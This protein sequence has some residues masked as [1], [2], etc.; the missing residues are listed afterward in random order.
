MRKVVLSLAAAFAFS[1]SCATPAPPAAIEPVA[2]IPPRAAD[3]A[4]QEFQVMLAPGNDPKSG[5]LIVVANPAANWRPL[6]G[7]TLGRPRYLSPGQ[8][9]YVAAQ[10]APIVTPAQPTRFDAD[11]LAFP[12]PLSRIAPGEYWVQVRLDVDHDAAYGTA[13]DP[14]ADFVSVP[15]KMALPV[16]APVPITLQLERFVWDP[17][18]PGSAAAAAAARTTRSQTPP[19]ASDLL[20]TEADAHIKPID[21]L[22]SALS[23]FWGKPMHVRGLVLLPPDYDTSRDKYP[24]IYRTEGFGGSL[25]SLNGSARQHYR[26]MKSGDTP[27]MIRVF[28]DHSS[29]W[30]THEFADSVNN[31]PWGFALTE[32]L[33]PALEKQYRMDAKPSGRFTTGHSSG[34][35]FAIWQQ[36]RYPE[37]FGGTWARSPDPV[38]FRSFTGI[39]IYRDGAN[40]YVRP[41]GSAQYLVRDAAGKEI[42]SFKEYALQEN[43]LGDFGG[44]IDSFDWVFSPKGVDG[45]PQPLFDRATGKVD[46]EVARYWRDHFDISYLIR[47]DWKS[48]KPVLDGK[49]RLIMGTMDTFHLNE[50]AALLEQEM[51]KLGAKADFFWMEGRTHGN[52]DRVGDDPQGLEKKIAWEMYAVARPN[53]P[54]KPK[55]YVAPPMRSILTSRPQ[56]PAQ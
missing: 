30:G 55:P 25:G 2:Q 39:D 49:I 51:Q 21:F 22:S 9:S 48:L 17:E 7:D 15:M 42:T 31:G 32:E 35:W 37:V 1:A 34:G 52:I 3:P 6:A 41:D 23:E 53:S 47:R 33:I 18:T 19:T 54:L 13:L 38:D 40:A 28:L 5:R 45:R 4:P 46:P 10:E 14:N 50:A 29:P 27:P 26:L 44:Q 43:V 8:T 12:A 20:T 56:P 24:T 16:A 36:V 11:T